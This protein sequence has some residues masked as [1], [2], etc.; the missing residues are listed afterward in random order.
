M[1]DSI[2]MVKLA[3]IVEGEDP[4]Y[5]MV[6]FERVKYRESSMN[7]EVTC[8]I[9]FKPKDCDSETDILLTTA[10][11]DFEPDGY[12]WSDSGWD[13]FWFEEWDSSHPDGLK[14]YETQIIM[15]RKYIKKK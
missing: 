8:D 1:V 3:K 5:E 4:D 7:A 15:V 9:T 12:Q 14:V 10:Q 6:Q 13:G 11:F 2:T